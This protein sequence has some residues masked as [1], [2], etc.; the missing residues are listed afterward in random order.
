[1][2]GNPENHFGENAR[3]LKN[4]MTIIII[5]II[6]IFIVIEIVIAIRWRL[7]WWQ[8]RNAKQVNR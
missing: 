1:M 8:N 5:N 6:I 4:F 7:R 2:Q 3:C